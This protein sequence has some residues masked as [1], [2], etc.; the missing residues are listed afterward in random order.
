MSLNQIK[1]R[2][3][4]FGWIRKIYQRIQNAFSNRSKGLEP[5]AERTLGNVHKKGNL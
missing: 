5:C 1:E 3:T 4:A 2:E